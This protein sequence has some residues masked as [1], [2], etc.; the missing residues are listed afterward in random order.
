MG[1]AKS[2]QIMRLRNQLVVEADNS[3]E[4]KLLSVKIPTESKVML[5]HF[6]LAHK[7]VDVVEQSNKI[8]LTLLQY[9]V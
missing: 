4:E 3:R 7:F 5:E 6:K 8:C 1:E 2:T 9:I